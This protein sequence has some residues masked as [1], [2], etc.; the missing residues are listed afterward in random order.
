MEYK[1]IVNWLIDESRKR[2]TNGFI[3]NESANPLC[4]TLA[5]LLAKKTMQPVVKLSCEAI[6][7]DRTNETKN[8][9]VISPYDFIELNYIRP[10][11]R[12]QLAA[13]LFIFGNMYR[14]DVLELFIHVADMK[15]YEDLFLKYAH[16]DTDHYSAEIPFTLEELKWAHEANKRYDNILTS[17][18]DPAKNHRWFSLTGRQKQ[19][20]A[21]LHQHTKMTRHKV[22]TTGVVY[23]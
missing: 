5:F 22:T 16:K 2:N 3:I 19:L 14:Q 12:F 1:E 18:I 7:F 10:W 21:K 15:Q 11:D 6:I 13:D 17:D 8:K 9:L 4:V 23:K 20:I